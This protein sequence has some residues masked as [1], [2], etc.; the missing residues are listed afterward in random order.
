MT[1]LEACPV[2]A[3]G[4]GTAAWRRFSFEDEAGVRLELLGVFTMI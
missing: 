1:S 2:F 4:D 3:V